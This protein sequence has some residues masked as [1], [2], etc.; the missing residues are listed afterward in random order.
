MLLCSYRCCFAPRVPARARAPT[1]AAFPTAI[2][3]SPIPPNAAGFHAVVGYFLLLAYKLLLT[4]VSA[5]AGYSAVAVA[6]LLLQY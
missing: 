1:V 4:K 3:V 5:V 2:E 6:L